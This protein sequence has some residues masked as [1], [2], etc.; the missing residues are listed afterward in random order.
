MVHVFQFTFSITLDRRLRLMLWRSLTSYTTNSTYSYSIASLYVYQMEYYKKQK[1]T[2]S[3]KRS[4]Q[5]RAIW[6]H[7][8]AIG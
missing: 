8:N 3:K 7:K 6:K 5:A 2:L 1:D 4:Q